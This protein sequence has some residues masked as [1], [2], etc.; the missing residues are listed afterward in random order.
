MTYAVPESLRRIA[1]QL[2][3]ETEEYGRHAAHDMRGRGVDTRAE[4]KRLWSQLEDLVEHRA[5]PA[6]RDASR[7]G[8]RYL[9]GGRDAAL[10]ATDR[11]RHATREHPLLAIGIAVATTWAVVS[12]LRWRR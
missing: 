10:D 5:R 4:L 2:R 7:E 9:R 11:L 3:T 12:L 8:G 1:R 6:V